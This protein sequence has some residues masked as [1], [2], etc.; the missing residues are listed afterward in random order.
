LA[1]DKGL[2]VFSVATSLLVRKLEVPESEAIRAYALS[3]AN[4]NHVY[5]ITSIGTVY[6]WDWTSGET[7][8]VCKASSG[9]I[10]LCVLPSELDGVRRDVLFTLHW[11]SS[12]SLK[13][14]RTPKNSRKGSMEARTLMHSLDRAD[15]FK[16]EKDGKVVAVAAGSSLFL[17]L[18]DKL[19]VERLD[20]VTYVWRQVPLS[21]RIRSLALQARALPSTKKNSSSLSSFGLDI[22]IGSE[23]G[24]IMVFDNVLN[25]LLSQEKSKDS[26]GTTL[27]PRRMHWHREPVNAVQWSADGI[28]FRP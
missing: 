28:L 9:A 21:N 14:Y 10:D 27:A 22:V 26:I 1:H 6:H 23:T 18:T 17:G 25:N 7:I 15:F 3:A 24:S 11:E 8:E 12:S 16:T 4:Q 19:D 2:Q 13:A 5:A 20:S